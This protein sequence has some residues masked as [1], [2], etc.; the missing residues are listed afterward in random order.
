MVPESISVLWHLPAWTIMVGQSIMHA[1][2][3]ISAVGGPP[4]SWG[5]LLREGSLSLNPH[6]IHWMVPQSCNNWMGGHQ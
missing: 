3:I 4:H 5:V 2:V 6:L 1:T